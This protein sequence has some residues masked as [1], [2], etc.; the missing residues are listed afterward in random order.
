[1]EIK[2]DENKIKLTNTFGDTYNG[3]FYFDNNLK[4][5]FKSKSKLGL[6]YLNQYKNK[7]D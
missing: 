2:V 4:L 3:E 5:Q 1:M 7:G 6:A